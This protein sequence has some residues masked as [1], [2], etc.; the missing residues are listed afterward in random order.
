MRAEIWRSNTDRIASRHT[1]ITVVRNQEPES[2]QDIQPQMNAEKDPPS[3][4]LK[5]KTLVAITRLSHHQ[6]K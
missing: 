6:N 3:A 2:R 5:E 1:P 4:A